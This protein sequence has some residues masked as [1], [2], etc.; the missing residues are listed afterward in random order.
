[1][2][3]WGQRTQVHFPSGLALRERRKVEVVLLFVFLM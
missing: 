2:G 3:S 1:M